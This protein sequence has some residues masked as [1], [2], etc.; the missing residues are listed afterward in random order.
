MVPLQGPRGALFLMSGTPVRPL[1]PDNGSN[2]WRGEAL[3][4][5]SR[6]VPSG[7]RVPR[8]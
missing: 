7:T 6:S 8:S 2:V 1:S 3:S 4:G 5:Q